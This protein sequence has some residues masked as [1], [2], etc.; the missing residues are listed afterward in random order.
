MVL[1]HD[2]SCHIDWFSPDRIARFAPSW[3]Y[4]HL[5]DDVLPALR[6][7]GVTDDQ[8]ETM[9][10]INPRRYFSGA[11]GGCAATG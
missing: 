5:F 7:R 8:I 2:A 6:E 4:R 11:A 9:L 10:V 3:H 1:S